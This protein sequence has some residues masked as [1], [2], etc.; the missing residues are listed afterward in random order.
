MKYDVIVGIDPDVEK[1]GF[2]VLDT[3]ARR[4]RLDALTF[5]ECVEKFKTIGGVLETGSKS[6]VVVVE[7]SWIISS[8][9]HLAKWGESKHHAAAKG[10]DVGRN[11]QVGKLIVEMCH[12]FDIP[13]VEHIPL[14]KTWKGKDR[15]ITHEELIQFCPIN[16]SRTNQEER[17]AA[18]LA[19]SFANFPIKLGVGK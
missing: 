8:N 16:K 13:V 6:I 11:H 14:I 17:D 4:V 1:N 18:L 19:W 10:Y 12:H 3:K 9:W 2:A 7:A 15:K 5:A